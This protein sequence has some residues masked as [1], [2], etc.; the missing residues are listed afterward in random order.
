MIDDPKPQAD[1]FRE[2]DCD[3]DE[4]AFEEKV[5]GL[6]TTPKPESETKD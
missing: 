3:E 4:A 2:L 6:A 5:R 1:N